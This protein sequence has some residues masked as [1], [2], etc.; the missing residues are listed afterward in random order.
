MF[1]P[2][3]TLVTFCGLL[4]LIFLANRI[5]DSETGIQRRWEGAARHLFALAIGLCAFII[6]F[7]LLQLLALFEGDHFTWIALGQILQ[8]SF[9]LLVAGGMIIGGA[10]ML[11]KEWK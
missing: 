9:I 10:V 4:S 6:L 3:V 8:V 11:S 5:F 1:F 7:A 2:I